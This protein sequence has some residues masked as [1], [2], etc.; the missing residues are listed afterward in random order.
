MAARGPDGQGIWFSQDRKIGLAHRRLSIIDL[1]AAAAQPM[2]LDGGR[3]VISYNG[4][5][6]N[7]M[8]LRRELEA[9]GRVFRS[10]SDTEV[11]LHL[12]DAFGPG[13]VKKLRGMFAFAIWDG[14]RQGLFLARD[15]FGVKPLYYA[16]GNGVF[17]A[18]SQVKALLAGGGIGPAPDPAGHAG[19]FLF[20]Y[21]PDPHTLYA[22]IRALPAGHHIWVDGKG[23]AKPQ[24]YFDVTEILAAGEAK[25]SAPGP[26]LGGLLRDTMAHHQVADVP[27]GVFLSA[28]RD[29]ATI[30]ALA[31]EADAHLKTV[32]LAFDEFKGTANDEAP[33][34]EKVAGLIGAEQRT[35]RIS[36]ADFH[37]EKAALFAAMDQPTI[38]GVNTYFVARAARQAGLKVALSGLGGDELFGGYDTF[39]QV[40]RM[41]KALGAAPGLRRFG[42]GLRLLGAPFFRL[43]AIAKA[44][45]PKWAGVLELGGG[46]GGAYLLRR[47]LFMPWELAGLLGTEMAAAGLQALQPLIRLDET[48]GP[49][50]TAAAKIS[51]LEICW[52]MQ[53]QLLRDSDWAG[54]AHGL[55]IRVPLVDGFLFRRLAPAIAKG[56]GPSKAAMAA[57]P[58]RPLP[59]SVLKRPKTGFRA[60]VREWMQ[61]GDENTGTGERGLRGWAK[62]VYRAQWKGRLPVS[63][64]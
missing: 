53:N 15:P 3:L 49:P 50:A 59:D 14:R 38:D 21:V 55:E 4:E 20:G 7:F 25:E 44:L 28:G 6:Y 16:D 33:L 43:P 34:A 46:W 23:P 1:S 51:A 63:R 52:Y 5:I 30:A 26:R 40:P 32:T 57:T 9:R 56:A 29:S 62:T 48:A 36:G 10:R 42:R 24:K 64:R 18:A 27:V 31:A 37:R 8:A 39:S 2:M 17:R 41:V 22:A 12:Y 58:T 11:L 45:S 19:F 60:P 35:V 13:M 54:M 61:G 47:G